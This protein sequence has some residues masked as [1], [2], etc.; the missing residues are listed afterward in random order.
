MTTL[1]PILGD[2]LSHT[3]ASLR[4]VTPAEAVVL[5]MEVADEAT[6]VPHHPQKIALFFSAMRHFA[7]EL[8]EQGW[9]V[10]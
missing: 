3:L 7:D 10:D 9:T 5:M 8:R 4:A 6:Y 1:V 2:Q